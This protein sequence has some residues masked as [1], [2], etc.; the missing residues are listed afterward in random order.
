MVDELNAAIQ[1]YQEKWRRLRAARTNQAFFVQLK[2]TS[3]AWKTEDLT[4]FDARFAELRTQADQIHLG[5]VND[6]WLATIHLREAALV[7]GLTVVKLMQRRPGSSDAIGLDHLDFYF[8]P[9]QFNAKDILA[10]ESGIEWNEE[11]NGI[12]CKWLSVWFDGTEAKIRSDTVLDVCIDEMKDIRQQ[13]TA[14]QR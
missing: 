4:D 1:E 9:V 14:K 13:V 3:V 12:H 6:R 2:P 11:R 7:N 10:T 8:D 5:W